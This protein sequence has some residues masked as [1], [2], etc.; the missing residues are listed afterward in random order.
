[1]E[2]LFNLRLGTIFSISILQYFIIQSFEWKRQPPGSDFLQYPWTFILLEHT[3]KFSLTNQGFFLLGSE[4]KPFLRHPWVS[5]VLLPLCSTLHLTVSVCLPPVGVNAGSFHTCSFSVGLAH[6]R[7]H[8]SWAL[9]LGPWVCKCSRGRGFV[10][11][12]SLMG[13]LL[14]M[15]R[16]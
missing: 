4:L 3:G 6:S 15:N 1:M 12:G 10:L 7:S 8:S 2:A 11:S 5:G 16:I 9:P 13:Y 14:K